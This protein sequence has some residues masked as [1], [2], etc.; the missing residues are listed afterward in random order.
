MIISE[1]KNLVRPKEKTEERFQEEK[2]R[3]DQEW[4][5]YF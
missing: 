4:N 1:S 3:E 2:V 5:Y